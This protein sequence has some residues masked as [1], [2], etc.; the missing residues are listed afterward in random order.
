MFG[1]VFGGEV[2][3][4]VIAYPAQLCRPIALPVFYVL[5]LFV[6]AVQAYVFFM[7]TVAFISLGIPSA[8]D[9]HGDS[10]TTLRM[11]RMTT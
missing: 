2:L 7:L 1:N 6:G 10:A 9:E 11:A 8:D 3:L 4:I 5:E